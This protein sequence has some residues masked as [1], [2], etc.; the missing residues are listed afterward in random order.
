MEKA[1]LLVLRE[2]AKKKHESSAAL[3]K[4]LSAKD[5]E[6][7]ERREAVK[8]RTQLP[9]LLGGDASAFIAAG[10]WGGSASSLL[11]KID[12]EIDQLGAEIDSARARVRASFTK[13]HGLEKLIEKELIQERA[14]FEKQQTLGIEEH[15]RNRHKA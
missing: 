15:V 9:P 6:L 3:L 11:P 10:K 14:A 8:A 13:M 2:L 1:R 12:Q 4:A 5:H 7:R